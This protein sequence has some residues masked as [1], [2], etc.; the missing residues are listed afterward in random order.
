[1]PPKNCGACQKMVY[2][3]DELK[4]LDKTWHKACF[5]CQVCSMTLNMKNYKGYNKLPYCNAHYPTTKFTSVAE[6]PE[7]MRIKKNTAIQSN[8][9]YHEEFE[10]AKGQYTAVADDP[11]TARVRKNMTTISNVAYHGELAKKQEMENAR[12]AEIDASTRRVSAPTPRVRQPGSVSDYDPAVENQLSPS[13]NKPQSTTCFSSSNSQKQDESNDAGS[14]EYNADSTE[15]Y[16]RSR[17]IGSITDY[18]PINDNYGSIVDQ[19]PAPAARQV[20]TSPPAQSRPAPQF[21]QPPPVAA[22]R[23]TSPARTPAPAMSPPPARDPSPPPVRD[24]SPPPARNPSPPPVR[25]P[26][27]PPPVRDPSPPPVKN[28]SPPPV[29]DPSPPPVRD[30]SPPPVRA[31]SFSSDTTAKPQA[32]ES[33]PDKGLVSKALYDYTAA[34]D[35]EVGFDEN[36]TIIQCEEIDDGWMYGTVERTGLRGMLPSNY[37]EK[38]NW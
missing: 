20:P 36:D 22:P 31:P 26:S 17:R 28:P 13:S 30:P 34:D 5:R 27:P 3:M 23:H 32:S 4:C 21:T 38:V 33:K 29:R 6:T 19:Y 1:M 2:P 9:K 12:P 25:N 11:E 15:P 14:T 16:S 8:I 10:A 18:D 37:V 35:D 7:N 24:L